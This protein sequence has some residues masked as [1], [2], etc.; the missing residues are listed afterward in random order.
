MN[1]IK[2]FTFNVLISR[3]CNTILYPISNQNID[4]EYISSVH[5]GSKSNIVPIYRRFF[6]DIEVK[7]GQRGSFWSV[8][9]IVIVSD[10]VY[11]IVYDT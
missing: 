2:V 6:F 10:T 8:I 5:R 7:N 11:D 9:D 1:D 4:L 3:Y